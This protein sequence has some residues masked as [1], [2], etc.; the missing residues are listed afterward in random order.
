MANDIFWRNHKKTL[1]SDLFVTVLR[2]S[3]RECLF[4]YVSLCLL[5]RM[6]A[7]NFIS[8][9]NLIEIQ[10]IKLINGIKSAKSV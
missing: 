3:L 10:H 8:N 4:V 6:G 1:V 5:S 9:I 7:E 2:L